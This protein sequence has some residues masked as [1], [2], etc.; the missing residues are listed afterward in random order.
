[1]IEKARVPKSPR[2]ARKSR[3]SRAQSPID[4]KP[5]NPSTHAAHLHKRSTTGSGM[6][7]RLACVIG[8]TCISVVLGVALI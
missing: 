4:H 1:M 5:R 8:S 6:P 2:I 7:I 3:P